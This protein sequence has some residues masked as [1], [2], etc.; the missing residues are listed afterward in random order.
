[1]AQQL[2]KTMLTAVLSLDHDAGVFLL[3]VACNN[4]F[5][6]SRAHFSW[7]HYP[8]S[9]TLGGQSHLGAFAFI[10]GAPETPQETMVFSWLWLVRLL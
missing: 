7:G 10:L 6:G 8:L 1:M 3:S 4:Y 9:F 2:S 5:P